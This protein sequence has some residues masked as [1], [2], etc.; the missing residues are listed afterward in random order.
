MQEKRKEMGFEL[1]EYVGK[2]FRY[3]SPITGLS[4]WVAEAVWVGCNSYHAK[5]DP[6]DLKILGYQ[7]KI[8][9]HT[10]IRN[11]YDFEHCVWIN[12]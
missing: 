5:M 10:K 9:V 1:E 3:N 11:F 8:H 7:H 12:D 4:D 6:K 2:K